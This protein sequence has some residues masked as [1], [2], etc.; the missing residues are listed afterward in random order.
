MAL[1]PSGD[2]TIEDTRGVVKALSAKLGAVLL[3]LG[4]MH[5]GNVYVLHLIRRRPDGWSYHPGTGWS[6]ESPSC[7]GAAATR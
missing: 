2:E 3:V 6:Y 1:Y 7:S 4:V 5:L